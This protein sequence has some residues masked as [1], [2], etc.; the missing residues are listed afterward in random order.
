MSL[1]LNS[2]A[3]IVLPDLSCRKTKKSWIKN[4]S[5]KRTQP[6]SD[7]MT[8]TIPQCHTGDCPTPAWPLMTRPSAF[9]SDRDAK[10]SRSARCD[11]TQESLVRAIARAHVTGHARIRRSE[12]HQH[13][14]PFPRRPFHM[15]S[16]LSD[17]S[18]CRKISSR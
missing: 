12:F 1:F 2:F 14:G 6:M 15:S 3:R 4:L 8:V 10:T 17:R 11:T 16:A 9:A 7:L 13:T 5:S 18:I